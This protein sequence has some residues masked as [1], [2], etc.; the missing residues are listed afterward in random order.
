MLRNQTRQLKG[1][2][3]EEIITEDDVLSRRPYR[4][5][6]CGGT[7]TSEEFKRLPGEARRSG[8]PD[9]FLADA[10]V[11]RGCTHT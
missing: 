10:P 11:H 2:H 7:F 6:I 3:L 5:G 9:P 8:L 1:K 4:C